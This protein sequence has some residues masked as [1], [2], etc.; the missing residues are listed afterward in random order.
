MRLTKTDKE[1]IIQSIMED[2]PSVNYM[3]QAHKLVKAHFKSITP[4]AIL[5]I[6]ADPKLAIHIT[7]QQ[8][9]IN[10]FSDCNVNGKFSDTY[11][12]YPPKEVQDEI[13]A[14]SKLSTKQREEQT[15]IKRKL[16]SAFAGLN[17]VKQA[18]KIFPEFEKYLPEEDANLR[19]LPMTI[20]VIPSL[21]AS[22]WPKGKKKPVVG[23]KQ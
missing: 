10:G 7:T 19:N 13:D 11:Y 6:L 12:G 16:E 14:L 22:G 17:T 21:V 18:L 5:K 23:G 15:V 20:D 4:P 2:L 9:N 1:I 3:E 8:I